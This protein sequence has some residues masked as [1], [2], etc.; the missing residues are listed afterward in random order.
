VVNPGSFCSPA[1]ASG[2]SATG[3]PMTC[4]TKKCD[5]TPYDQPR[6]RKKNC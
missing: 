4:A 5:G 1:G 2:V 3:V 6:W